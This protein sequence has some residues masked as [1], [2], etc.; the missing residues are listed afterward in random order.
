MLG[1][2]CS[3]RTR[4][5]GLKLKEGKLRLDIRKKF[6]PARVVRHWSG[7]PKEA[8]NAPSLAVLQARLDRDLS[9]M[10]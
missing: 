8:V 7:F 5:N 3:D 1:R 10:V 2:D 9:D 4:G 6:F